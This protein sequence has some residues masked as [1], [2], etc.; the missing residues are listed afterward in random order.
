MDGRTSKLPFSTVVSTSGNLTPK[1]G[2]R[3]MATCGAIRLMSRCQAWWMEPG[4]GLF[5]C[6]QVTRKSSVSQ[7]AS[8]SASRVGC[9]AIS[10]QAS[11]PSHGHCS[12]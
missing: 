10:G 7:Y 4:Q 9:S 3:S 2:T 1:W 6:R 8:S 11:P 12:V 5:E